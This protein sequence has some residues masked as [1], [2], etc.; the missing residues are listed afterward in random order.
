MYDCHVVG[1][2]ISEKMIAWSRPRARK[3]RVE[4]KVAFQAASVLD[5]PFDGDLFD[6]VFCDSVIALVADKRQA[7]QEC[8]RVAKPAST[9]G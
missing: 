1:V 7:I 5:L 8:V 2:D 3:E 9:S 4:D 6:V